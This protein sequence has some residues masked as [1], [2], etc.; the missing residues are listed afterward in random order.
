MSSEPPVHLRSSTPQRYDMAVELDNL[1]ALS[2][3]LCA[4]TMSLCDDT[5]TFTCRGPGGVV[6]WQGVVGRRGLDRV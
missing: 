1:V 3:E 2:E 4:D 6:H 5:V